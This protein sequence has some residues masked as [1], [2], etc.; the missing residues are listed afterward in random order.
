MVMKMKGSKD[1]LSSI[2]KTTQMGQIGI[3]SILK[4]PLRSALRTELNSQLR[5]YDAIE[6]EALELLLDSCAGKEEN[7]RRLCE[8]SPRYRPF[9]RLEIKGAEPGNQ[10]YDQYDDPFSA[11]LW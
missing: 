5:E 11:F 10:G 9:P 2:L 1:I 6:R 7:L 4:S 8:G 3:R